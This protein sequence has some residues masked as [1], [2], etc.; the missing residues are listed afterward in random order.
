MIKYIKLILIAVAG[1][2]ISVSV[3]AD[4]NV[5]V[6]LHNISD[7]LLVPNF[8]FS[9][10][11]DATIDDPWVVADQYVRMTYESDLN[12]WIIRIVTNNKAMFPNMLGKPIAPGPNGV[13]D[14]PPELDPLS[15]D[16]VSYGGLVD[17]G[18]QL[19]PENRAKLAWQVFRY[20]DPYNPPPPGE[21]V[22]P[23]TELTDDTVGGLPSSDWGYLCDVSDTGYVAD[24]TNDYFWLAYG[25]GAFSLIAQH[26]VVYTDASGDP[27]PKPGGGDIVVY[28]GACLGKNQDTVNP[29]ALPAGSYNSQIFFQL[30][31]E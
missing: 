8:T 7:N 19:N 13:Y 5:H 4:S 24:P 3:L 11:A 10:F 17:A 15:D 14:G 27:L 29:G 12:M 31:H 25:S 9:G 30:F 28:I 22:T 1:L 23:S 18:S 21:E 16:V 6:Q 20:D 2:F 26:P